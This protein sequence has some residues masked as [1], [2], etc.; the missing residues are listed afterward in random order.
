M[1]AHFQERVRDEG[2][3]KFL[4]EKPSHE[5]EVARATASAQAIR[6]AR[7]QARHGSDLTADIDVAGFAADDGDDFDDGDG[8][9]EGDGDGDGD[10]EGDGEGGG[11]A[12]W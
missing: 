2:C 12:D 8:D 7:A 5:P 6:A 3:D 1:W 4:V 10:G 11:G 9:G